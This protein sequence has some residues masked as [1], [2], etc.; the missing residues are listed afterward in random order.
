MVYQS[1]ALSLHFLPTKAMEYLVVHV[2]IKSKLHCIPIQFQNLGNPGESHVSY[3]FS[4]GSEANRP[5]LLPIHR[6]F[7]GPESE[8][9]V[10]GAC[11][12]MCY[13]S[14]IFSPI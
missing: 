6:I 5:T 4:A 9:Y 10:S 2:P 13:E 14:D 3:T 12:Q 1:L 11:L 7:R 8:T